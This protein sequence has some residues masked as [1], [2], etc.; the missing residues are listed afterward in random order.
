MDLKVADQRVLIFSNQ[1]TWD[2]AYEKAWERKVDAFGTL[3]K[4]ES[5]LSRPKDEDFKVVYKEHR[6]E[7]FWHVVAK[8]E[9]IYDRN[10]DYEVNVSGL[11]VKSVSIEKSDY[12]QS[13]G[14]IHVPVVEH[15][16]QQEN[17]EVFVDAVTGKN[18]PNLRNYLSLSPKQVKNLE[19]IGGKDSIVVP[20]Q[21]RISAIMR[22][23]LSK[24]IKGIQAD[25][26]F[27]ETVRVECVDLYYHPVY[28][29][30][31]NWLSKS[32]EAIVEVD[33]LNGEIK[34]GEKVF[35]EYL[36]KVLDKNFLFDLG[37]D[38]A[39]MLIPGGSIAVKIAKK[40]IDDKG[41]K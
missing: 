27:K 36:G 41:K 18:R 16:N 40:Y 37:A 34:W 32:K 28:A 13:N 1:I 4:L 15:C 6:Y 35:S 23:S 30:K 7:P 25:K 38:A 31:F 14:H 9:Y 24:M 19:K 26:I 10:V 29:F 17:E 12:D 22:D 33:G 2:E 3:N 5:F 20:P 8:A 39:G 11:E 21:T